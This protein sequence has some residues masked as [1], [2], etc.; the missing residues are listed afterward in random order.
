MTNNGTFLLYN[1]NVYF[2]IIE[3]KKQSLDCNSVTLFK[4]I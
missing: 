2:Y 4:Y 1:I 3:N